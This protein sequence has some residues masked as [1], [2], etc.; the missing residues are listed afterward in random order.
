MGFTTNNNFQDFEREIG[1]CMRSAWNNGRRNFGIV[2]KKVEETA[3]QVIDS[4]ADFFEMMSKYPDNNTNNT[5]N[6]INNNHDSQNHDY[7]SNLQNI[8]HSMV[9]NELKKK[10]LD[11]EWETINMV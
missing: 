9:I 6:N 5:N 4:I 3:N 11:Q 10:H 8:R 7:H 2:I 1:Q